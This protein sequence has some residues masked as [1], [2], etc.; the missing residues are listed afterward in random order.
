[1]RNA[2]F[3]NRAARRRRTIAVVAA[4]AA[5]AL[6]AAGPFAMA[7]TADELPAGAE[8]GAVVEQPADAQAEAAQAGAAQA[9]PEVTEGDASESAA[10]EE[11]SAGAP[12]ETESGGD[13]ESEPEDAAGKPGE[14][15]AESFAPP[16]EEPVALPAP[17]ADGP[18]E[19]L[20]AAPI[21]SGE[22]L[23]AVAGVYLNFP[24]PGVLANDVDPDGDALELK[25][26]GAPA[27]GVLYNWGASGGVGYVPNAGFSGTDTISYVVTDGQHDVLGTVTYHVTEPENYAPNAWED[28]ASVRSG[29]ALHLAAAGVLGNDSDLD[30]DPLTVTEVYGPSHGSGTVHPDGSVDYTPEP[31]YVGEDVIAYTASDGIAT[32]TA[33]LVIAVTEDTAPLEPTAVGDHYL[34]VSGQPLVV[35]APGLLSNDLPGETGSLTVADAESTNHGALQWQSDGSLRYTSFDGYTGVETFRY[36][37][38]DG[39]ATTSAIVSITVIAAQEDCE[40]ETGDGP[41]PP[42]LVAR[43]AIAAAVPAP[44]PEPDCEPTE[45][46]D[47][48]EP[49]TPEQ[50]APQQ[51]AQPTTTVATTTTAA[52]ADTGL[53]LG[54][55]LGIPLLAIVIGASIVVARRRKDV[56]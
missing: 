56:G 17:V 48:E 11:A 50:P 23:D 1:M 42:S 22:S 21:V 30:G 34:A 46:I 20:N 26:V 28:Y 45:P 39:E 38:A 32:D 14:P 7:A 35:P 41:T 10:Q 6:A 33:A 13:A 2:R 16:V 29:S 27:H 9:A 37:I 52:L 15:T 47:P 55:L 4:A 44:T 36:F 49:T 3:T 12:E 8:P 54:P 18:V 53:D 5:A 31:G 51:P 24:S 25:S 19:L 40:P 43:S